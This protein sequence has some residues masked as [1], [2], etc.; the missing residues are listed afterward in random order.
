MDKKNGREIQ[1]EISKTGP[2]QSLIVVIV[3]GQ[4]QPSMRFPL[5]GCMYLCRG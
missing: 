3:L 4:A 1:A 5:L 2:P